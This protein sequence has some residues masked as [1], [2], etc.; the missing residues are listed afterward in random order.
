[1]CPRCRKFYKL[2]QI[3]EEDMEALEKGDF[4]NM[5]NKLSNNTNTKE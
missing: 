1:M 4:Q 3:D 5:R 2:K